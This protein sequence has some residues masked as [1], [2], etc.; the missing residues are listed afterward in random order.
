MLLTLD[1][2]QVQMHQNATEASEVFRPVWDSAQLAR[3]IRSLDPGE[4]LLVAPNQIV[5]AL[6][7]Q[8]MKEF[9][10]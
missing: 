1:H 7:A 2:G 9:K 8:P 6:L 5:V 3:Q 10:A 4:R